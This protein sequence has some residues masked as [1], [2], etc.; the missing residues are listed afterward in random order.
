MGIVREREVHICNSKVS[1]FYFTNSEDLFIL[2]HTRCYGDQPLGYT[3][4]VQAIFRTLKYL[5]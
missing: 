1:V 5:I 2:K 3:N 4:D